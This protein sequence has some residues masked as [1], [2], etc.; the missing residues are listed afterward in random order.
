M[1]EKVFG[2]FVLPESDVTLKLVFDN[3]RNYVI[4]GGFVAMARW[5]ELGKATPPPY[6]YN[7]PPKS[8][9]GGLMW[10]SLV[11]AVALY[12]LNLSQSYLIGKRMFKIMLGIRD[13]APSR[14][15]QGRTVWYIDFV[16]WLMALTFSILVIG[17]ALLL[18]TISTFI[19]WYAVPEAIR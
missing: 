12:L 19:V 16:I 1:I 7:G 11:I 18:F 15:V 17:T 4:V 14:A 3:L 2:R 13:G 8:G 6:L 9:W 10:L 5:F